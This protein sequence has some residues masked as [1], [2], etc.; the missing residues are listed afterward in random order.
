[1]RCLQ[2]LIDSLLRVVSKLTSH[3]RPLPALSLSAS[4]RQR[5]RT[6]RRRARARFAPSSRRCAAD[7]QR[8]GWRRLGHKFILSLFFRRHHTPLSEWN[9]GREM[10]IYRTWKFNNIP[11]TP[12]AAA[13]CTDPISPWVMKATSDGWSA[14]VLLFFLQLFTKKFRK[15]TRQW[16][17]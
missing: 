16:A 7:R 6:Y 13:S 4:Q 17:S 9:C 2:G 11:G 5:A 8:L 12:L 14:I 15:R 3:C 1:M 10:K